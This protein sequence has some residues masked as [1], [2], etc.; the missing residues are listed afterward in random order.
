R[1]IDGGVGASAS[2]GRGEANLFG[3]SPFLIVEEMR[4]GR[5]A[6]DAGMEALRRIVT[7]TIE[8]R[9]LDERG[10][11]NF[12]VKFYILDRTGRYAGVALYAGDGSQ[13]YAL[14]TENGAEHPMLA[15]LLEGMPAVR[16]RRPAL[17]L[18]AAVCLDYLQSAHV[19]HGRRRHL[20]GADRAP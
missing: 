20:D 4:R 7:N 3:L 8:P 15:P 11:P 9:L 16:P 12:N 14:C 17:R 13:R 18:L 1:S 2:T 10:K 5:H 19:A 6:Q